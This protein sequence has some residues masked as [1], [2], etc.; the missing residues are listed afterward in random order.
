MEFLSALN[1]TAPALEAVGPEKPAMVGF[2]ILSENDLLCIELY[3]NACNNRHLLLTGVLILSIVT[4]G[5]A[6]IFA[7][8]GAWLILPFAGLEVLLLAIGTYIACS[9]SYDADRLVISRHY[10]H[11]TQRRWPGQ[12]VGSFV[13]QW[14]KFFLLPG[15]TPQAPARLLMVSRA[16]EYEIGEFLVESAKIRL[17]QQ[18]AEQVR[19]HV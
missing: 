18:L 6:I 2:E 7:I 5:I 19:N 14:T 13:R 10:V 9:R 12:S 16:E 3:S 1:S 8:I 15:K 4:I 17:F 11:L